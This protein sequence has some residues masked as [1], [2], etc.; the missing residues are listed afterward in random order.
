M[1]RAYEVRKASIM[2]TGAVKAKLYS[3]YAK[4]IYSAAK[5]SVDV[6]SNPNLKRLIE[7]AKKDQVP[8]DIIK[9]AIDKAKSGVNENYDNLRYEGFGPGSSTILIDCLTDNINRTISFI[10]TAFSKTHCK[11]GSLNSISY[12]YEDLC[13]L[14]FK[15]LTEEEVLEVLINN[16]I[17]ADIEKE[18][19]NI[20]VYGNQKDLFKIKSAI[21]DYKNDIV[22]DIDELTTIAKEKVVLNEEDKKVFLKLIELLEDIDDVSL[23]YHN[24]EL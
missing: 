17:N 23:I 7:K 6:D 22:F 16:D 14:S 13:V 18:E 19:D 20:I 3:N 11:L 1:G 15:N 21:L 12:L 8:S 2:K 4:E 5:K 24:V 9:R 10:R